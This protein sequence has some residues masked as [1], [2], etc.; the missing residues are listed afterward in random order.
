MFFHRKY[1]RFFSQL[2]FLS[3]FILVTLS[4]GNAKRISCD[5]EIPLHVMRYNEEGHSFTIFAL[6]KMAKLDD[7][8]AYNLAIGSQLPDILEK[9]TA[10]NVAVANSLHSFHG[11]NSEMITMRRE[12]LSVLIEDSLDD[13]KIDLVQ[14]GMYIHAF[15]D[16]YAHTKELE[17]EN[18]VA[19]EAVF[20]HIF[21]GIKPDLIALYKQKY[22]LYSSAIFEILGGDVSSETYQ[23]FE[24]YIATMDEKNPLSA[25]EAFREEIINRYE[26]NVAVYS[27]ML[28]QAHE[29]IDDNYMKNVISEIEKSID[30]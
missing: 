25:A 4:C 9:Y 14:I 22:L 2:I 6:A 13:R 26:F 15:G 18:I 23:Q 20:G 17:D 27:T 29:C 12:E 7:L 8:V 19:Y 11:G 30:K 3:I 21:D 5:Q 10:F 1:F 28:N 16:A 24:S